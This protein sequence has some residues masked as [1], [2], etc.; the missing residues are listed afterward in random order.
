M[1]RWHRR[2]FVACCCTYPPPLR[3]STIEGVLEKEKSTGSDGGGGG[4][5][6]KD[7]GETVRRSDYSF[8][9]AF[10]YS[11]DWHGR[12]HLACSLLHTNS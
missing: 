6:R 7:H 5:F 12:G 11:V 10:R 4:M 3:M 2:L 9:A 8:A 1:E